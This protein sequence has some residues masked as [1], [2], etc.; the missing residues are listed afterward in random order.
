MAVYSKTS[1]YFDTETSKGYLDV[2]TYRNFTIEDDDILWE[3]TKNYEHRP[4]LLAY[5]LYKDQGL[6]W[7]FA[8]RNG[9]VLKDPVYDLVAGA[10]IYLPKISTLRKDLGI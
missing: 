4:D 2:M 7:V 1:P 9:S 8:M 6:W 3:V 5:H 10:K